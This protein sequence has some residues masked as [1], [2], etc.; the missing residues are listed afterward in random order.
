MKI[1]LQIHTQPELHI[2]ADEVGSVTWRYV[3]W[4]EWKSFCTLFG[5]ENQALV[6]F[7]EYTKDRKEEWILRN[8]KEK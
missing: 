6:E 4:L 5:K 7:Y 1:Q 2:I 8:M 3:N